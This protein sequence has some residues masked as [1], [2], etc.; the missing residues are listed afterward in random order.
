[1]TRMLRKLF[2]IF[3]FQFVR[4]KEPVYTLDLTKERIIQMSDLIDEGFDPASVI[5]DTF[6]IKLPQQWL[7]QNEKTKSKTRKKTV[8]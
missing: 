3:K 1:M 6:D 7:A 8:R 4:H 5:Q 2:Q